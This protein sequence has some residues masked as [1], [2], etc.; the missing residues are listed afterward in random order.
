LVLYFVT[1]FIFSLQLQSLVLVDLESGSIIA[2]QNAKKYL[3]KE[4]KDIV[5]KNPNY[6]EKANQAQQVQM[7]FSKRTNIVV[8]DVNIFNYFAKKDNFDLNLLQYNDIFTKVIHTVAFTDEDIRNDFN[9]GLSV[10][11]KNGTYD[12]IIKSY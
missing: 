9:Y 3:G 7:L 11:K 6:K 4:Y 8:S 5:S 2:F 12:K 10:I 1:Y